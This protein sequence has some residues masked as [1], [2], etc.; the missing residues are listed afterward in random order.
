MVTWGVAN[1]ADNSAFVFE[2]A[3]WTDG[4]YAYNVSAT[5]GFMTLPFEIESATNGKLYKALGGQLC[6]QCTSSEDVFAIEQQFD[7]LCVPVKRAVVAHRHA[8]QFS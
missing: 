5:A 4:V 2:E 7:G 8:G 1:G 6:E 3:E